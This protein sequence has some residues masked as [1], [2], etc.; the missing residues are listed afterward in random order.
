MRCPYCNGV[1]NDRTVYCTYCGRNMLVAPQ[2]QNSGAPRPQPPRQTPLAPQPASQS[3]RI[4]QQPTPVAPPRPVVPP[5]PPI[6]PAPDPP[7]PFPPRTIAHLQ[8]LEPGALAYTVV[9]TTIDNKRKKVVRIAYARCVSWQQVATLFKAFKEQQEAKFES[10]VI[11]GAYPQDSRVYAF[12]NGQ[13]QL[14]RNVLL[15]SKIMDRY[16]IETGT[17]LESDALRIVLNDEN[18]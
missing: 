12:T 6:P 5:P 17:G 14:D 4:R 16:Q 9:D 7:A 1:N 18:S 13:L 10:I 11:Q 3:T 15:G 2:Q 8:A